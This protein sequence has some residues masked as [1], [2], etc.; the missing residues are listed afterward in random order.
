MLIE[1]YSVLRKRIEGLQLIIIGDGP[2]GFRVREVSLSDEAVRWRGG[3]D[4]E[5]LI[6]ADMRQAHIVFVPGASGLSIVHAFCY[7]KPYVTL[8]NM[9][10]GPELS[11]LIDGENGLLLDGNIE[12]DVKRVVRLLE[13]KKRYASFCEAS[14]KQARKL[15][16]ENWCLQMEH[17]LTDKKH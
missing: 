5:E 9:P 12:Q 3:V 11:Y 13:D 14:Y 8:R 6:A 4:D 2:E 1:Y 16:I 10:H 7:G 17:A 15:S